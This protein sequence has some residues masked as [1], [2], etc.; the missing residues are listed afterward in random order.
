[1]RRGPAARKAGRE[2]KAPGTEHEAYATE[3]MRRYGCGPIQFCG[4]DATLYER[5]LVFDNVLAA[6][7][8]SPRHQFEAFAR[9]IRDVLAQRWV[10]TERSIQACESQADLLPLDGVP[11]RKILS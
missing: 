3:L 4:I 10:A 5:H 9:S 1:M 2:F 6:S 11:H 7:A 8:A